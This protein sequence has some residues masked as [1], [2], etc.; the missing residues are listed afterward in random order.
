MLGD[1][2]QRSISAHTLHT[3]WQHLG[4]THDLP[5]C[6]ILRVEV[7]GVLGDQEFEVVMQAHGLRGSISCPAAFRP[8]VGKQFVAWRFGRPDTLVYAVR[9]AGCSAA[10]AEGWGVEAG[11]ST[12][13]AEEEAVAEE[14]A[15]E[16]DVAPGINSLRQL[17]QQKQWRVR[18]YTASACATTGTLAVTTGGTEEGSMPGGQPGKRQCIQ[19]GCPVRHPA[20]HTPHPTS[21]PLGTPII[22]LYTIPLGKIRTI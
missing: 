3:L 21:P 1:N 12:A 6:L 11:C 20:R 17:L 2:H 15:S 4:H 9:T 22:R 13:A 8:L 7:D 14:E 5:W 10:A 18:A 19:V 16:A